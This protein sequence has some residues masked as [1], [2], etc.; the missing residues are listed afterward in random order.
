MVPPLALCGP[1][2]TI[3]KFCRRP[4]DMVALVR[5]G[6]LSAPMAAFLRLAVHARRNI[7]VSGGTG[8]GK[9]TLLNCLSSLIP[10]GERIVTIEDSAELQLSHENLVSL[11]ARPSNAEGR[12]LVSIRDLVRNSLRMRPDRV[13]VGNAVSRGNPELEAVLEAAERAQSFA[14]GFR[15]R[16]RRHGRNG[17]RERV[18]TIVLAQDTQLRLVQQ[19]RFRLRDTDA[20][21]AGFIDPPALLPCVEKSV[22]A[23]DTTASNRLP[24]QC[25]C[26][27]IFRV[28]HP[29]ARPRRVREQTRLVRI[30]RIDRRVPVEMVG[31]KIREHADLRRG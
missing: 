15:R 1:A 9:T 12:G 5:N 23:E 13:V 28:Q 24:R 14:H 11:E 4:L 26:R 29:D 2:V 19:T 16:P 31:R 8:T 6:S 22:D 18:G 30:V 21:V 25:N 7:V 10:A 3:R 27:R 20:Q 17:G